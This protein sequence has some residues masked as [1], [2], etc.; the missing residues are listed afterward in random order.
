MVA[1]F[2]SLIRMPGSGRFLLAAILVSIA[3]LILPFPVDA[4]VTAGVGVSVNISLS[5]DS[6][7]AV[8]PDGEARA[9]ARV[10]RVEA[11]D[12]AM[13]TYVVLD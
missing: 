1:I 11:A 9:A 13:V 5:V 12:S 7:L 10:I 4:A 2:F 6:S 8:S 3:A